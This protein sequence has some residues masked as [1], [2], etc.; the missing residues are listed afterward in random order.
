MVQ[1]LKSS[2]L[3]GVNGDQNTLTHAREREREE[4]AM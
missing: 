3:K 4:T 2:I 1:L